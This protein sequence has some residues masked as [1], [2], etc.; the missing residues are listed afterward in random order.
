MKY[1]LIVLFVT[2]I[3]IPSHFTKESHK[4]HY[5]N[6]KQTESIRINTRPDSNGYYG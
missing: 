2:T 4:R 6:N 5:L 3:M 1:L